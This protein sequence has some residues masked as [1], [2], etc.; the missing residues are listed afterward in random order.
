MKQAEQIPRNAL[1]WMIAAQ[2][3]LL[4]PHLPRVPIWVVAVSL[5]AALWRIMVYR[6]SWSFPR[7]PVKL[8]LILAG[9]GG[10]LLSFRNLIG[11]EPMVA[12]LLVAFALKVL[13]V[14]RRKD[15]YVLL[16]LGYFVVLTE[17][18]FSQD[19]LIVLLCLCNV[20][21]V[22][23]ALVALHRPGDERF[24]LRPLR[25]A[26][27]MVLQSAPLMVV[28]FF[29]FPR[30][31]P[32]WTVPLK[33]QSA[34]TGMSDFM[35]PGDVS[36]LSRSGEVAF[37]V[38][39]EG[40]IPPRSQLYWR[41]L[42]MSRLEAGTWS[43]L[44]Y[45]DVPADQRRP[46]LPE[47]TEAPLRYSVI[48]APTQQRWLYA[49]RYARSADTGIMNAADYRL[50]RPVVIEDDFRYTVESWPA[51]ELETELSPWRQRTELALPQGRNPRTLALG[52]ELAAGSDDSQA[53]VDRALAL[54]SE[55]S[56]FYTLEPP[57]LPAQ[58][59]VDAFLFG[60]RRGFCEHYASA[61]V[62]L[63][64]AAGVPARVVAGYQGGEINP[65]NR[66]V[67]VH[68]FDAHAWAEVWMAGRGWVRVDPT[69]AVSPARVEFGLEQAVASEGTFLADQPL[70]PLRYRG[71]RW[72][73][74]VRLR[75][76]ALTYRWQ[77]WVVSFDGTRQMNLLQDWLGQVS[78]L[79]IAAVILGALALALLPAAV[80]LLWR[81][82]L[83]ALAPHDRLYLKFCA[84]LARMGVV[85]E[86]GEAPGSYARRAAQ[87]VP[88]L[89]QS[90]ES[91]T[92]CYQ[93][94]A[95]ADDPAREAAA[96]QREMQQAVR[97]LN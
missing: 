9:V 90:I 44:D 30:V 49:L 50:F 33:S 71:I 20:I 7:W 55:Q 14:A 70:S 56:F 75:Y 11:L 94:L 32:L 2:F 84:R 80:L 38:A 25:S 88:R 4:A 45:Y 26:T 68:Q 61:F 57:T 48:M 18:L 40:E 81:R 59:A 22:T 83:A 73:N 97:R 76:D 69:S 5:C 8:A 62:V 60:T 89:A 67:I 72:I 23:T 35:R 36:R 85:R 79:R 91:I 19:L 29:I 17:F 93:Q 42:V 39:F 74:Q 77:S 13:E 96:L 15:A 1:V 12:L 51:A 63:M 37:R 78:P 6:G 34:V 27:A 28:L 64:R 52:Q 87:A 54:F 41:G 47:V 16:F 95:Y 82:P 53:I 86:A 65:V 31:G 3:T 43:T 58:D 10:I 21:L 66:T 24:S 46:P 92:R